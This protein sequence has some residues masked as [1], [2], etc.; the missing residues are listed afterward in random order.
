[1]VDTLGIGIVGSGFMSRTYVRGI[2]NLVNGA[3]AMAVFGGTRADALASEFGMEVEPTL[4]ALLARPDV[5]LVF[6]GSPTQAHREQAEV[7]AAA[8][9]HVFT[10]KPMAATLE[11]C[12]AMIA[13][14][15]QAGVL[16]GVNTV[17][18]YRKG[19]QL[20]KQ[21]LEEGAIG[22]MRMVRH[23]Y[24]HLDGGF[25]GMPGWIFAPEAGSPFL[26]QGSHCN[27]VIRW[28]VG[29]DV[30]EVYAH[31]ANYGAQ[32]PPGLSAIVSYVFQNGVMCQIFATYE[33]PKP[34][35]DPEKWTGDYTFIGSE[36]TID[37]QYRGR[38]R[39]GRGDAWETVYEHP[40]VDGSGTDYD[41]N[42]VY[43]YADQ[44]Q[45][46][47]DAI[48]EGREPLVNGETA[49]KGIEIG[50]AADRSAATGQVVRLPLAG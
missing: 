45:D 10:E 12:D 24:A 29:S 42:F 20:A 17:T 6:L 23:L 34:A 32:E 30:S 43:P 2:V 49:R 7:A 16:L 39:I 26:D 44:L 31:Y 22:E 21:L 18:R 47:V 46:F 15:R 3:K 8:G 27:D 38:L 5:D 35:L 50:V 13:A 40:P 11:E 41:P 36:G 33:W 4:D 1:M 25:E 19:F 37:V 48:R 28:F 14:T 9:K